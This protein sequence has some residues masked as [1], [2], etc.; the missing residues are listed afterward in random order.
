MTSDAWPD[1]PHFA[2]AYGDG[3]SAL[4]PRMAWRLWAT[5]IALADTYSDDDMLDLLEAELPPVAQRLADHVWMERFVSCFDTLAT[6]LVRGGFESS[7]LAS[8]TGEEMAL[9]LV[10][11]LAESEAKDGVIPTNALLPEDAE[12]DDDFE[13]IR[14][15]LF[16]DHDVLLLFNAS[17]D[18]IE[19]EESELNQQYR[20]ANLHPQQ[21]FLPF[22]DQID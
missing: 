19:D 16:R 12:R 9:H 7:Q 20:L 22:A 13:W 8:C 4:S 17:L 5:A 3:E 21:W 11:D 6:R 14:E 15:A 1:A 18:G 10:I 2:A